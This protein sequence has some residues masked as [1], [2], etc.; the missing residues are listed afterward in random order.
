MKIF[1]HRID[2][3]E[4]RLP[5]LREA[6]DILDQVIARHGFFVKRFQSYYLQVAGSHFIA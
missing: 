5:M 2:R 1:K 6:M 4:A 3:A